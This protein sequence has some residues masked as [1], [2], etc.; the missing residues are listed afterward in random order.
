MV[1]FVSGS[2]PKRFI[3]WATSLQLFLRIPGDGT[4]LALHTGLG[5]A[6]AILQNLSAADF[7]GATIGK[8]KRQMLWAKL[9]NFAFVNAPAQRLTAAVARQAPWL[10]PRIVAVVVNKTRLR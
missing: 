8:L 10:L 7:Q 4:S 1:L 2:F 5:A 3:R 9:A 6:R